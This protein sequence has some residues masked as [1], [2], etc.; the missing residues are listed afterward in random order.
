MKTLK[1]ARLLGAH[2]VSFRVDVF[3]PPYLTVMRFKPVTYNLSLSQ[4]RNANDFVL[5]IVCDICNGVVAGFGEVQEV[6]INLLP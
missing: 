3:S 4:K 6:Y 2:T 5:H 1:K